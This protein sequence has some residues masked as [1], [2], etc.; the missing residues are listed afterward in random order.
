MSRNVILAL[1]GKY[2][3]FQRYKICAIQ[4]MGPSLSPHE[5]YNKFYYLKRTKIIVISKVFEAFGLFFAF[6][7]GTKVSFW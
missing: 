2:C 5:A 4:N 3:H 1:R 7:V 6:K